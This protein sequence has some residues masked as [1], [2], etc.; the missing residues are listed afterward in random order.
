MLLHLTVFLWGFTAILGKSITVPA[1]SIVFYRTLL[2]VFCMAALLVASRRSVKLPPA[3]ALRLALVG[4]LV[5]VH[6]LLF[7]GCIQRAGVAV[8]VLCLSTLAFF[9]ALFEPILFRRP[10]RIYEIAIGG[11]AVG[12]VVLL[13]RF[14]GIGTPLGWAMGIGSA[15]FSAVF[16]TLNGQLT[17]REEPELLTIYELTGAA[18]VTACVFPFMPQTW[19]PPSRLGLGNFGM[20]IVLAIGCTVLPWMWSL[21]VLRV[22]SP[23]VVALAVT[24]EPV[25]SMV[26]ARM[27]WPESEVLSSTFYA[28]AAALILLGPCNLLLRR[29]QV[30]NYS[31]GKVNEMSV[32]P[33]SER[34]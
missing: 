6:W 26:L 21:R 16:G 13:L 31:R 32:P 12:G 17:K 18:V 8:A 2:V 4:S 27:L 15:L 22:L 14:E 20:L 7:Y 29:A 5:G 23:Y 33:S 28:G 24:L 9:T 11:A 30:G 1:V 10:I 3:R 19:V 34:T 25:Y